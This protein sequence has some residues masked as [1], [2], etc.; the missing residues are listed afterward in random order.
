MEGCPN[1][2]ILSEDALVNK[3]K[4]LSPRSL[5]ENF[6][7]L[8]ISKENKRRKKGEEKGGEEKEGREGDKSHEFTSLPRVPDIPKKLVRGASVGLQGGEK[9]PGGRMS[10]KERREE[11]RLTHSGHNTGHNSLNSLDDGIAS[12]ADYDKQKKEQRIPKSASSLSSPSFLSYESESTSSE[13]LHAS[14]PLSQTCLSSC[15][16]YF[17]FF[18]YIISHP[19]FGSC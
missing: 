7:K 1:L 9:V 8:S 19:F 16:N 5:S 17:I 14:Q 3:R 11:K 4:R 13:E 6:F 18:W 2:H 15:I 12:W 10:W